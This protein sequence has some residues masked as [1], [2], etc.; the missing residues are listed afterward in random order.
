[1]LLEYMINVYMG[2]IKLSEIEK[3]Y[4]GEI[5]VDFEEDKPLLTKEEA[6]EYYN[7]LWL[8]NKELIQ[9]NI[10][11]L[12]TKRFALEMELIDKDKEIER[13]NNKVEELMTLY[14]TEREVKED[15]KTIIKEVREYIENGDYRFR[16]G[17]DICLYQ[18]GNEVFY[19]ENDELMARKIL[20]ILD[21][22]NYNGER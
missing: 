15:Y 18:E 19:M 17:T 13:L 14:T 6:E 4:N 3:Y 11:K 12:N 5:H 8:E 1:M 10:D 20:S 2:V 9:E 16:E 21:K 22:E 7:K